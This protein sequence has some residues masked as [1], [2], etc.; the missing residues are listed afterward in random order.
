MTTK[1]ST[2]YKLL[3]DAYKSLLQSPERVGPDY[4]DLC[5]VHSAAPDEV[6]RKI[7]WQALEKLMQD[8]KTRSIGVSNYGIKHIVEMQDYS[9]IYPSLVN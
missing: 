5:L 3:S 7:A 8:G 2:H 9:T 6:F 1:L 4:F